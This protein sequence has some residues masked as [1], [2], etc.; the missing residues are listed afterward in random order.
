MCWSKGLLWAMSLVYVVSGYEAPVDV[1]ATDAET[2]RFSSHYSD[3]PPVEMAVMGGI[4]LCLT[5]INIVFIYLTGI[6]LLKVGSSPLS[7]STG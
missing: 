7:T 2:P 4:S 5:I 1:D 6:L 3:S